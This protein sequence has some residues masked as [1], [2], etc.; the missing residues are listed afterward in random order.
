MEPCR[1]CLSTGDQ[2]TKVL[3][4]PNLLKNIE[5]CV[6]IK[7]APN[8]P[9][10]QLV[11]L[12]CVAKVDSW[13]SF[14]TT[15][16]ET[17]VVLESNYLAQEEPSFESE[18]CPNE[19]QQP[20]AT[21][22]FC[23][24]AFEYYTDYLDHLTTHKDAIYACELCPMKFNSKL[25]LVGHEKLHK[26]PCKICGTSVKKINMRQH[27]V[28]HTDRFK[29]PHCGLTFTCGPLL[30]QHIT[31]IH[32]KIKEHFCDTCG[33]GFGTKNSLNLHLKI[34]KNEKLYKCDKCHFAGNTSIS[35]RIHLSTHENGTYICEYCPKIF[36]SFRNLRDHLHR[37]HKPD[38]KFACDICDMRFNLRYRVEQHKRT[39]T[40]LQPFE[41]SKC[42]KTFARMDGLKEHLQTH[43][44]VEPVQCGLCRKLFKTKRGLQRHNCT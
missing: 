17:K 29:C 36:K 31:A 26:I 37:V 12:P 28:K 13:Y 21:C 3:Q 19:P 38:K 23:C 1:L 44:Q 11:C 24:K 39:H 16:L 6:G 40:G 10:S 15:C 4:H 42:G 20:K 18:S 35:L 2:R 30:N 43:Q 32:M 9:Y 7:I 41:C 34:H 22:G 14:K 5:Q 33:K 25:L 8:D 27:L